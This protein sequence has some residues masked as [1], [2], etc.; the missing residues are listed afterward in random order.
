MT[1]P[2]TLTDLNNHLFEALE[3]INDESMDD[4]KLALELLR[5][6]AI[7]GISSQIIANGNLAIKAIKLKDQACDADLKLPPMLKGIND[8]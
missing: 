4:A 2:N 8:V 7:T 3:R 1:I 6:R 5:A